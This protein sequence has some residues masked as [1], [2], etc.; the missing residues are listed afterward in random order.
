MLDKIPDGSSIRFLD[1]EIA[2]HEKN[3]I[4]EEKNT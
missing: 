2:T 1:D 3:R 4:E